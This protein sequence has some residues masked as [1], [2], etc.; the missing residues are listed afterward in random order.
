MTVHE[1]HITLLAE[2]GPAHFTQSNDAIMLMADGEYTHIHYLDIEERGHA[3]EANDVAKRETENNRDLERGAGFF[4]QPYDQRYT[5]DYQYSTAPC[6][7]NAFAIDVHFTSPMRDDQHGAGV[8]RIDV[9]TGHVMEL[10]YTPNIPAD[11]ANSGTVTETFG[12]ALPGLWTIVRIDREYSGRMLFVSG[13]G[14]RC[15]RSP[16]SLPSFHE[17]GDGRRVLPYG[18]VAVAA[19]CAVTCSSRNGSPVIRTSMSNASVPGC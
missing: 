7:C 18:H 9:A 14:T 17:R 15:D 10:S 3:L 5:A 16:R 11:H 8:M 12:Q 2:A 13:H 19:F 1:R 4:K 6:A